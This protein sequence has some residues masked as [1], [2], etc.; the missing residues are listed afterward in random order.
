M[1]AAK[2]VE[3]PNEVTLKRILMNAARCIAAKTKVSATITPA[4]EKVSLMPNA[5]SVDTR[6]ETCQPGFRL[7]STRR[8][9][10]GPAAGF[11]FDFF[12]SQR[13]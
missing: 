3:N 6:C 12:S 4:V 7:K 10:D 5:S 1:T 2:A 9:A 13:R 8:L 11:F